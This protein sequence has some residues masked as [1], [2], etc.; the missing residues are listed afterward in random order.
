[1][2]ERRHRMCS[3]AVGVC[4]CKRRSLRYVPVGR[5]LE[6]KNGTM[7]VRGTKIAAVLPPGFF[8]EAGGRVCLAAGVSEEHLPISVP[9]I[10]AD[11]VWSSG[12]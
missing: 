3:K 11:I 5:L 6:G 9:R 10:Q 2:V 1:M 4:L 12:K 7:V 8:G